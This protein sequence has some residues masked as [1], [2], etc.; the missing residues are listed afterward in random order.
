MVDIYTESVLASYVTYKELYAN[1]NYRSAYQI[2][3]EFIKYIIVTEE[4]YSFSIPGL[5]KRIQDI[6]GFQLP[7]AVI[8]AAIK[9]LNMLREFNIVRIIRLTDR[10][11]N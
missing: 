7:N 3:A 5:K 4:I 11:L 8:K 2:L 1:D 6:F 10:I 9:K